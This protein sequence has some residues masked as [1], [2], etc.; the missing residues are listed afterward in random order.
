[1]TTLNFNTNPYFDDY[2]EDKGFHRV[3]FKPGVSVQARELTQLQTILQKQVERFG[4][5]FF[6]EGSTVIPG[7]L[8]VDTNV[9]FLTLNSTYNSNQVAFYLNDFIGTKISNAAGVEA[10]VVTALPVSGSNPMTL[11]VKY[12]TA[13]T[14]GQTEFLMNDTIISSSGSSVAATVASVGSAS[15]ASISDGVYF[16]NGNFVTVEKQ[17]IVLDRY[18]NV[19]SYRIGLSIEENLISSADDASLLDNATGTPNFA[20][21]G[22]DR[23]QIKLKLS[24]VPIDSPLDQ[25][26]VELSRIENGETQAHVNTTDYAWFV[27]TLARR[28]F[29]ESGS[30]SVRD[31]KIQ[32]REHRK[33]FRGQ[34]ETDVE[35]EVGD[36]L[37][38]NGVSYIVTS[39]ITS[40]T[41]PTLDTANY[42]LELSPFYNNGMYLPEAGGNGELLAIGLEPG[43]AYV[44]G[45]EIETIATKYIP[46][47]KARDFANVE[48]EIIN[49]NIGHFVIVKNLDGFLDT[50]RMAT[51]DLYDAFTVTPNTASGNKVGTARVRY[52]E[53][54]TGVPGDTNCLYKI[55][56]FDIQM[57]SGKTFERN[58]KQLFATNAGSANFTADINAIPIQLTGAINGSG[59][60]TVSGIGTR[61][62]YEVIAGDYISS[63]N[64]LFRVSSITD[65][66]TLVATSNVTVSGSVPARIETKI[67][68]PNN[69]GL[70][71]PL[72]YKAVR[73]TDSRAYT[74]LQRYDATSSGTGEIVITTASSR[75]GDTTPATS[76]N[77][78]LE[79]TDYVVIRKDTGTVANPTVSGTSSAL[80]FSDL[81]ASQSYTLYIPAFKSGGQADVKVKT[82]VTN[83]S[84]TFSGSDL[85]RTELNLGK[86]DIYRIISILDTNGAD[87]SGW[88]ALDDGQRPTHYGLGK[89][90]KRPNFG[91]PNSNITVVFDYFTHSVGDHFAKESYTGMRPEDIPTYMN[92][93]VRLSDCIDFRPRVSD[94][95]SGFTGSGASLTQMP[96]RTQTYQVDY[97][98]YL[99]R[100]DKIALD[101][102]GN[103]VV[104]RGTSSRNPVPPTDKPLAMPLYTIKLNPYTYGPH[105][106]VI[107]ASNNKRYTMAD[108]GKLEKRINNLEYY[109][110][111][112]LLEQDTKTLT[113]LD[114]FGLNRFK[115][116]FAVDSFNGSGV[117]NL[118]SEEF[119]ASM[120]FNDGILRPPFSVENLPILVTDLNGT[121]ITGSLLTLDYT[122]TQLI[123]Q[124]YASKAVNINPFALAGFLGGV[125]LQPEDDQWIDTFITPDIIQ[126][127]S[128]INASTG[129]ISNFNVWGYAT[130]K[131][132]IKDPNDL[133]NRAPVRNEFTQMPDTLETIWGWWHPVPVS[134]EPDAATPTAGWLVL[135]GNKRMRITQI[136]AA[137]VEGGG[138]IQLKGFAETSG[139]GTTGTVVSFTVPSGSINTDS[140]NGDTT[141]TEVIPFIRAKPVRFVATGLRPN[142]RYF[143]FFESVDVNEFISTA[144]RLKLSNI[145]GTFDWQT[146]AGDSSDQEE[147]RNGQN[148]E[149][150]YSVGDVVTQQTTGATGVVAFVET[151][152]IF[153][154]NVK[155]TFD[156]VNTITGSISGATATVDSIQASI[157]NGEFYA[158]EHGNFVGMFNIP[159]NDTIR[160]T[161]GEKEFKVTSSPSNDDTN[162]SV[163]IAIYTTSGILHTIQR[164]IVVVPLSA[165]G[166]RTNVT[167]YR[168]PL[169][170]SFYVEENTGVFI[171]KV[172]VFFRTKDPS[173]PVTLEIRTM[174]NGYPSTTVV[175]FGRVTL[176]PRKVNVSVDASAKTTFVFESPIF[177]NGGTEYAVVLLSDSPNYNVW[178]AQTGELELNSDRRISEQPTLGV[179]FISQ[180][181]STWEAIQNQDL[182]FTI[183]RAVFQTIEGSASFRNRAVNTS[184]LNSN[185]I[186][187]ASGETVA[188]A[189]IPN[190]GLMAGDKFTLMNAVTDDANL[191]LDLNKT[192]VVIDALRHYVTFNLGNA[193]PITGMVG[194]NNVES[195]RNIGYDVVC[196]MVDE[197]NYP[198]TTTEY[199]LLSK[200]LDNGSDF[201]KE[202]TLFKDATMDKT[203]VV[204][205]KEN[206]GPTPSLRLNSYFNTDYNT[207][208]PVIDLSRSSMALIRN[209]ID[210]PN[211]LYANGRYNIPELDGR[212]IA[213]SNTISFSGNVMSSTNANIQA[214]FKT[215]RVGNVIEIQGS[216][217]NNNE[218]I[219]KDINVVSGN[220]TI[221][222]DVFDTEAAGANISVSTEEFYVDEIASSGGSALA[223][224]VTKELV[225]ESPCSYFK[226]FVSGSIVNDCGI[227]VYYKT[228][229]DGPGE[230]N[231]LNWNKIDPINTIIKTNNP[232]LFREAEYEVSGLP[233][234][235]SLAI[236][237]VLRGNDTSKI[238]KLRDMRIIACA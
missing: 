58:V 111:L 156:T 158:S 203:M 136:S 199:V 37:E 28:T 68:E 96:Y 126:Q 200:S 230:F 204:L 153:V 105:D 238:P 6:K 95:G 178:I 229:A 69:L 168:D 235:T 13:G 228:D 4:R 130:E 29:D 147:R 196:P 93:G 189:T 127:L 171:T 109:T 94:D 140:S 174:V 125:T 101:S 159:N 42:R 176:P 75:I 30:Y 12:I 185:P 213:N 231:N 142:A 157:T 5:H 32:P 103:F 77:T 108:I 162:S 116:G 163:G 70:V 9:G 92:S 184:K 80:T 107:A 133:G 172:D 186:N 208:S 195:T 131:D 66:T 98:Y 102:S 60:T 232:D 217:L 62:T 82:L 221:L 149:D 48:D 117:G 233:V 35:Y 99:G 198:D 118:N 56:L 85:S 3:L 72:P 132:Y 27:D 187:V 129:T 214:A 192:H 164:T 24:K 83:A 64:V 115:N 20:A 104:I 146:N 223:K 209:K 44:R 218:Y 191:T 10:H 170:Q 167:F 53:H 7:G 25:N 97:S 47:Q 137:A 154:V 138:L 26:F 194:G 211:T 87:Y 65:D 150:A 43:K 202:V 81:D 206:E 177:L 226:M 88:Y 121:K 234:F 76:F 55:S 1:M 78:A 17:T 50:T 179:L 188:R 144:V 63:G 141:T 173:L 123:R 11:Y 14:N 151:D 16:V 183:H 224:Y 210:C 19:P 148:P 165:V 134:F 227:D 166:P 225:F 145:S 51:I 110:S 61:F 215:I 90:V 36:I 182:K 21:P 160:F 181:A 207:V 23:Y 38:Y 22:A 15:I 216:T 128:S 86:A 135:T 193:S 212:L 45:Y 40:T 34:W 169:S 139:K 119:R 54:H 197:I 114:E 120:D 46:I 106:I 8:T 236:K 112:N 89:L 161:T 74:V 67:E 220:V 237:I 222:N 49:T 73:S 201:S 39:N 100:I 180:N 33:N 91:S 84:K 205:S 152:A 52:L 59:T 155:G 122:E 41:N 175:P 79:N 18:N 143:V 31:F 190:N 113:I 124:P 57:N 2:D 71:Y 219:V